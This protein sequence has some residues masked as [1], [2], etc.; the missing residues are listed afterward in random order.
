MADE[1]NNSSEDEI[2]KCYNN[3]EYKD[4]YDTEEYEDDNYEGVNCTLSTTII[5]I[6]TSHTN[7]GLTQDINSMA[8]VTDQLKAYAEFCEAIILELPF[9]KREKWQR[10]L[11]ILKSNEGMSEFLQFFHILV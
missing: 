4:N 5:A 7:S 2:S 10:K 1:L 11:Q 3:S 8:I 9:K 6:S